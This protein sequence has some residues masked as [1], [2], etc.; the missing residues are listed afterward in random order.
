M[1]TRHGAKK[2]I[3]A[4]LP[5][6]EKRLKAGFTV[7]GIHADLP[8]LANHISYSA[9]LRNLQKMGISEKTPHQGKI[10]NIEAPKNETHKEKDQQKLMNQTPSF[11]YDPHTA[12]KDFI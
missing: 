3:T 6:I 11:S 2:F 7:K 4:A 9:V 5:E 8:D 10:H 1:V 12:G